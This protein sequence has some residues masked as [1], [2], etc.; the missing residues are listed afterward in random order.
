MPPK[1]KSKSAAA[2]AMAAADAAAALR[3]Q[4]QPLLDRERYADAVALCA[5]STDPVIQH[6]HAVALIRLERYDDALEVL[7]V[8]PAQAFER[9]YC[10]YRLNR[11]DDALLVVDGLDQDDANVQQLKAQILYRLEEWDACLQLHDAMVEAMPEVHPDYDDLRTNH[12]AVL[13][14]RAF[15]TSTAVAPPATPITPAA[16]D[17]YEA[18]FNAGTLALA[19][20]QPLLAITHLATAR[21]LVAQQYSHP[22]DK[23][24]LAREIAPIAV[25]LAAAYQA[26]GHTIEAVNTVR[27]AAALGNK[28]I[29]WALAVNNAMSLA[30]DARAYD[31]GKQ[32]KRVAKVVAAERVPKWQAKLVERNAFLVALA[33]GKDA[34][35][36]V[37]MERVAEDEEEKAVYEGFRQL[38]KGEPVPAPTTPSL[39]PTLC[40]LQQ[41]WT[42]TSWDDLTAALATATSQFPH[43][44]SLAA[45]HA[46]L[47]RAQGEL[48]A[49]AT[50]LEA[51]N[52]RDALA[53]LRNDADL[54]AELVRDLGDD[55]VRVAEW[56]AALSS[57][58]AHAA[59]KYA[60]AM[61]PA[62]AD[63]EEVDAAVAER[64]FK[65]AVT[66]ATAETPKPKEKT[67]KKRKP[68]LPK[69]YDPNVMPDPDRWLPKRLRANAAKGHRKNKKKQAQQM[70]KGG[71][72]GGMDDGSVPAPEVVGV[73]GTG[74]ARI[75]IEGGTA[76]SSATHAEPAAAAATKTQAA[77]KPPA[78]KKKGGAHAHGKG[79]KKH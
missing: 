79:K 69:N 76:S 31:W 6:V 36:A 51:V 78:G 24:I 19:V 30:T 57:R 17:S 74:S 32:W 65:A 21:T 2:A 25:Q 50:V 37:A 3:A 15:S 18:H 52:A 41:L 20:G 45:L 8:L 60:A 70:E 49:A 1:N 14:A 71:H 66:D 75:L 42:H 9:A 11:L 4:L 27:G 72:Q 10:L 59:A 22:R 56:I 48:D 16:L 12:H 43:V 47:L 55:P 73:G 13:A 39:L 28:G 58:D 54:W 35:V 40:H 46:R 64:G 53:A 77:K 63:E 29:A 44:T 26:A 68:R 38:A 61:L 7:G 23:S 33:L 62:A 5:N 34:D 67:K